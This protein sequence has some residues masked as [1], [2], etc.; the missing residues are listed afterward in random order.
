MVEDSGYDP[1]KAVLAQQKLI[2][3][4]KMFAML[5]T[6]GT[7]VVAATMPLVLGKNMNH[8]FPLTGAAFTYEPVQKLQVPDI[9]AVLRIPCAPRRAT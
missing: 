4:D 2:E 9:R 7:P 6:L 1:K 8:L 5:G 3:R